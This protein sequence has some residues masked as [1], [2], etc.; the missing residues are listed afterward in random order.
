MKTQDLP[1][2]QACARWSNRILIL[3]LL[4]IAWLTLFPFQLQIAAGHA[5]LRSPFLLGSSIKELR[6]RNFFLNIL[7]FVPFGFGVCAQLRKRGA[8]RWSSLL[9][10]LAAGAVVSY[11]VEFLQLY[12][13]DRDSGWED[14]ISNTTGSVAGFFLFQVCGGAIL[15]VLTKCEDL[16]AAWLSPR[17]SAF[18]L[19]VY[20]AGWFGV[21][22][23]WQNETRLSNWDPQCILVAG[24][25]AAGENP[26]R[27]QIFLL[28]IWNRAL[29]E[30]AIRRI[31]RRESAEDARAGLLASYNFTGLPPYQDQTNS[32]AALGWTPAQPQFADAR[33]PELDG[34]AWLR[35]DMAVE[36]LTR[37]ISKSNQ[38]TIHIFCVPAAT[39]EAYGRIVSLSQS[40][41]TVNF[42]M[43]QQETS[44]VFYF[45]N[46]L[47]ATGAVLA[48]PVDDVFEAGKARDIVASYDGSDAYLYVDGVRVPQSFRLGPGT[49]ILHRIYLV[50]PVDL[51]GCLI[52]YLTLVFLPAGVLIGVGAGN[53]PRLE[54]SSRWL[55]AFGL[56]LPAVLLEIFL[57]AISGRSIWLEN[58]ALGVV[59]GVGGILLV[60]ADRRSK[61]S[62]CAS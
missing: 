35:T 3:S 1:H 50:R 61:N 8:R 41:D 43:R 34:K 12:I 59:F 24:N 17:R 16:F 45:R 14:V 36:K 27:G 55:V 60:N 20:F 38:F 52:V 40:D 54:P 15:M 58:I 56:V 48:W 4:G 30:Q 23:I 39:R 28:Q 37:E 6:Y 47:S 13:P 18:L 42:H 11:L 49:S 10:A 9:V 22:V 25:D 7:L 51:E 32:L 2:Q 29:P 21:S 62:S 19:A 33:A 26:W 57:A 44:L 53:W 46:P 5:F 31:S